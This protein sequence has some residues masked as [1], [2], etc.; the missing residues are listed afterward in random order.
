MSLR[1]ALPH[2]LLAWSG[3]LSSVRVENRF[4]AARASRHRPKACKTTPFPFLL[5]HFPSRI[6]FCPLCSR[7]S[8]RQ[9]FPP[10]PLASPAIAFDL[11]FL[12]HDTRTHLA[13]APLHLTG[14]GAGPVHSTVCAPTLLLVSP[15]QDP[16]S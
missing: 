14:D 1:S 16:F 9:T 5:G 7:R 10:L 12:S 11:F 15:S 6:L 3:Q 4:L 2:N 13:R 8:N